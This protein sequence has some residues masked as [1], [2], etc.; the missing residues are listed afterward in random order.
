[1]QWSS[2][3]NAGFS[4][5][6]SGQLRRPVV[7]ARDYHPAAINVAD[8]RQDENSLLN[9]MERLIRQGRTSPEIGWGA[10]RVLEVDQ[11]A[12]LGLRYDWGERIMLTLHNLSSK[13]AAPCWRRGG[14]TTGRPW[15]GSLAAARMS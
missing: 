6:A 12:V 11:K 7:T 4:T 15:R 9:W 10:W 2:D 14:A 3:E 5:A 13:P 1:M 8:Q